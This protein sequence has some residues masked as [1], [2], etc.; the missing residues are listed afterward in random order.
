M[1]TL[2]FN[3]MRKPSCVDAAAQR[4]GADVARVPQRVRLQNACM[5]TC[6]PALAWPR[7]ALLASLGLAALRPAPAQNPDALAAAM[8][9]AE[10]LRDAAR[11]SGDQPYGAVVLRGD[12]IVGAAPSRVVSAQDPSAHAEREALRDALRRLQADTLAGCV[13]VSTSRPC[14]ACESA[15]AAAGIVRMVHG[16]ALSDA[17]APR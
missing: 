1:A 3:F 11:R 15:A 13:L 5:N 6:P 12:T 9:Q 7:R 2:S 16:P 14:G 4:N 8:R 10:A 17:G